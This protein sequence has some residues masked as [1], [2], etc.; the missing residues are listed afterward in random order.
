MKNIADR[1]IQLRKTIRALEKSCQRPPESVKIL[2]VSKTMPIPVIEETLAAGQ[3][4]FGE[5]YL[6][7]ALDKINHFG[8]RCIEWHFI[9]PVQSNKT[10]SI[11]MHFDWCHS[12]D[13]I[14]IAK[15]LSDARGADQAPLNVCIQVNISHEASKSGIDERA[16]SDLA[17]RI[18]ELPGLRLRGLMTM[19]K[20]ADNLEEQRAPFRQLRLLFDQLNAAGLALD[21]LSMG[22][23]HDIEAAIAE[24]AT[25]VRV[26][27]AIFGARN[28]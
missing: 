10:R 20:P 26:G 14:K 19:P 17:G 11:A 2:A 23:S 5:N 13:R 3:V 27:T 22:T 24:G 12:L 15:R 25:L 1:L 16:V 8:D 9:G 21:T 7:E 28:R 18:S 6:Q 4:A